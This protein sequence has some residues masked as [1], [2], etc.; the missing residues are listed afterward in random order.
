MKSIT[1]LIKKDLEEEFVPRFQSLSKA[2]E[3]S[4]ST[5]KAPAALKTPKT[6]V[7]NVSSVNPP[8]APAAPKAPTASGEKVAGAPKVPTGSGMKKNDLD[9]QAKPK[10]ESGKYH[11]LH[12]GQQITSNSNPVSL[13]HVEYHYGGVKN[14]ES[15]GFKLIP[16]HQVNHKKSET[17]FDE[18]MGAYKPMFLGD[19]KELAKSNPAMA[20]AA[21][22]YS[23]LSKADTKHV[24]VGEH[25][26]TTRGEAPTP[27]TIKG[28]KDEGSGGEVAKKDEVPANKIIEP[29]DRIEA[30]RKLKKCGLKKC[31]QLK[32]S[33]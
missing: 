12:Q 18:L 4:S 33:S 6:G 9:E 15:K 26:P 3:S 17:L 21:L 11:I 1:D 7:S 5:P 23:E 25:V 14:L 29:M 28:K 32:Q 27:K 19:M 10:K 20:L 8:K 22:P 31:G 13:D 2:A 24:I 16:A 30:L